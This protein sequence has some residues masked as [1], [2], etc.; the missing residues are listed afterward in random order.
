MLVHK[1]PELASCITGCL[2]IADDI[3]VELFNIPIIKSNEKNKPER[4]EVFDCFR[5]IRM[6]VVRPMSLE[7][8]EKYDEINANLSDA[9]Q[10]DVKVL[11]GMY[12][13]ELATKVRY[14]YLE[15]ISM[16]ICANEFLFLSQMYYKK[17]F[18]TTNRFIEELQSNL[19]KFAN[20]V[21]NINLNPDK[22]IEIKNPKIEEY[23]KKIIEKIVNESLK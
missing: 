3:I 21:E 14:E 15:A 23:Y 19:T 12:Q 2:Q 13:A 4:Y 20:K 5:K 22:K 17:F 10:Q 8:K 18:E 16:Y 1:R 7:Q 11:L 6:R 9:L